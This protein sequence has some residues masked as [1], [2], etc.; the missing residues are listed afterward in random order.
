MSVANIKGIVSITITHGRSDETWTL[1]NGD[2]SSGYFEQISFDEGIEQI[3]C[4]G[5]LMIRDHSDVLR[6]F[7]FTGRDG[8]KVVINDTVANGSGETKTLYFIIYQVV[9]ATDYSDRNQ[10]RMVA[11]KFIDPLYFYNQRRPFLYEEDIK[12][13]SKEHPQA[14]PPDGTGGGGGA[15]PVQEETGWVNE[16]FAKFADTGTPGVDS[17]YF[18]DSSKN[19]AWLK[20][21][22]QI[23]PSGR[24]IDTD[25]FLSLLNYLATNAVDENNVPNFFCWKDLN[26]FNFISY[27]TMSSLNPSVFL[28]TGLVDA[29]YGSQRIKINS[30]NEITNLSL[31]ELENNGAFSSYYERIDPDFENPYF[32]FSDVSKGYTKFLVQYSLGEEFRLGGKLFNLTD[33]NL[34][35]QGSI[36][37]E[38]IEN[39]ETDIFNNFDPDNPSKPKVTSR[40][41]YDDGQWGSYDFGYF[42]SSMPEQTYSLYTNQGNTFKYEGTNRLSGYMWQSMFDIEE[43]GPISGTTLYI[44]SEV[45]KDNPSGASFQ[46]VNF[47]KEYI[48][49]RKGISGERDKYY[50]LRE[51]KERWNIFKYVVCCMN[52]ISDSFYALILGATVLNGD[53]EGGPI[54][55]DPKPLKS[56]AFK[57]VWK[58][59]EFVPKGYEGVSGGTATIVYPMFAGS[60]S[61][62][63]GCTCGVPSG[64]SGIA[65]ITGVTFHFTHPFFE[66]FIPNNSRS[67]GFTGFTAGFTA[68]Y[69]GSIGNTFVKIPTY[70]YFPAFNINEL[71]NYETKTQTELNP[72]KY[73]GAGINMDLEQFPGG[74]KIIPVGYNPTIDDPC[75]HA[76]NGQIVKMQQINIKDLTGLSLS[77]QDINSAPVLYFFDV[78]NAVEGQC[79]D[80]PAEG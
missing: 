47:I 6:N 75:K 5:T 29:L 63:G 60:S 35:K 76:F 48:N 70:S 58:E 73:A 26:S 12:Q 31:M 25:N 44:E 24:K 45:S 15:E 21:K 51:L 3:L 56:K 22:H 50:K 64:I 61:S 18:I 8:L 53:E 37:P 10:A 34:G 30:I 72:R 69:G 67:G 78:Q 36:D 4:S 79:E 40:R 33:A 77:Q 74:N 20:E 59:V 16:I 54:P 17:E 42:N 80:C 14:E 62:A 41:F 11:L 9:H 46:N 71:T 38:E 1:V 32:S 55:I 57:Y 43:I 28:T 65:G 39:I 68:D 27:S 49:I 19:Y 23:Y 7:N 2:Y 66:I 52:N 13:I